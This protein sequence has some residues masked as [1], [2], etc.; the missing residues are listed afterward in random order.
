MKN[1]MRD[2]MRCEGEGKREIDSD[3]KD[4]LGLGKRITEFEGNVVS[5]ISN[6][7][8]ILG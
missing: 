8:F 7:Y 3:N 4:N 6:S 5:S 2:R 1:K